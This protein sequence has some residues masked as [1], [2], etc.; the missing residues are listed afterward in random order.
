MW[1]NVFLVSY[2]TMLYQD[3][4]V[5]WQDDWWTGR[6]E[7]G[8]C[9]EE[10]YVLHLLLQNYTYLNQRTYLQQDNDRKIEEML[11]CNSKHSQLYDSLKC[12]CVAKA[13]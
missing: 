12:C 7:V 11:W 8:H 10:T 5:T 6:N 13:S 9:V 3:Y 1:P 2:L 4:V